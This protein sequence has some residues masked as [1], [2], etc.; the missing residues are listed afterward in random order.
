MRIGI[1]ADIHEDIQ[2]LKKAVDALQ[3]EPVERLAVLGDLFYAGERIEETVDILA[4]AGAVGVWGN[5]DLGLCHEPTPRLLARY[6]ARVF[7]F[8]KTLRTRLEMD[9]CLFCHGLPHWDP[10]DPEAY[11]LSDW[12]ESAAGLAGSFAASSCRVTFV[13]HFHRWLTATPE[14][15]DSWDGCEP[16]FLSLARRHLVAVAAVCDGWCAIYDSVS[17]RLSPCRIADS[18]SQPAT[19]QI[20]GAPVAGA[21]ERM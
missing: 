10:T 3:T 21:D 2:A 20:G 4:E 9:G 11:Y 7:D 5:H 6:P 12:P 17:G 16:V 1:L 15:V 13:G 19:G 18:R 14:G 8:L